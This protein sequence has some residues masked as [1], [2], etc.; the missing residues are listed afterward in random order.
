[1]YIFMITWCEGGSRKVVR[2][3]CIYDKS[4]CIPEMNKAI[5]HIFLNLSCDC[6]LMNPSSQN[7]KVLR[8]FHYI[9][10]LCIN[11]TSLLSSLPP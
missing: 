11:I 2:W 9:I 10:Y 7:L 1:M 6:D 4:I 3:G 5:P 8:V